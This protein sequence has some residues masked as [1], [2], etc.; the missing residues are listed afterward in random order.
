[1]RLNRA[2]EACAAEPNPPRL[3]V[4]VLVV[5]ALVNLRATRVIPVFPPTF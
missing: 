3:M 1:M 4:R 5:G 2:I